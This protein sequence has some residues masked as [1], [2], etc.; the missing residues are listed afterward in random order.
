MGHGVVPSKVFK[1]AKKRSSVPS[2]NNCETL[3]KVSDDRYFELSKKIEQL[4]AQNR[5]SSHAPSPARS[6]HAP[7][8]MSVIDSHSFVIPSIPVRIKSL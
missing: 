4:E 7:S 6:S 5:E 1:K 3:Q 2:C 8:P